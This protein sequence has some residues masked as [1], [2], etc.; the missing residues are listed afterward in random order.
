MLGIRDVSVCRRR[1][2]R[3]SREAPARPSTPNWPAHPPTPPSTS[4]ARPIP[5]CR[6]GQ[7]R[8][9]RHGTSPSPASTPRLPPFTPAPRSAAAS[10][11]SAGDC[12][13]SAARRC[14]RPSRRRTA[15]ARRGAAACRGSRG[16]RS[17]RRPGASAL[18]SFPVGTGVRIDASR[19]VGDQVDAAL[20]R[21]SPWSPPGAPIARVALG[22]LR[23]ALAAH[24]GRDRGRRLQ[25]HP[26][27]RPAAHRTSSSR[28]RRRPLAGRRARAGASARRRGTGGAARGRGRGLRSRPRARARRRSSPRRRAAGRSSPRTSATGIVLAY[29]GLELPPGGRPFR[30]A[31]LLGSPRR[32]P[33]RHHRRCTGRVRASHH[34]RRT[35]PPAARRRHGHAGFASRPTAA[36][37]AST[38]RTA[39]CVRAGWPALVVAV[40]C[41]PGHAVAA[42]DPIAVLESMKM[43]TTVSGAR[44]PA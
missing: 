12:A 36:P 21:C 1:H 27:A 44:W 6:G 28:R 10:A 11:S 14:P 15:V 40:P 29:G 8:A 37:I 18:L 20:T 30:A 31:R 2:R 19:R 16:R 42:G 24:R 22:R 26:A 32:H 7:L 35:P 5:R 13:S 33:R 34:L 43:E 41:A 23:R 25:P 3:C 9:R 4:R 39:S 17:P 38:A